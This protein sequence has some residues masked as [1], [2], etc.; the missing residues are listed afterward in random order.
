MKVKNKIYI[1]SFQKK[2]NEIFSATE[3][4]YLLFKV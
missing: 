4:R 1:F 3:K 2:G